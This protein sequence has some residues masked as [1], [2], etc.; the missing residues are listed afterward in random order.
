M[1]SATPLRTEKYFF[2]SG[3]GKL[4]LLVLVV[5]LIVLVMAK[6]AR[7][8][9]AV[10]A[11]SSGGGGYGAGGG[12]SQIFPFVRLMGEPHMFS[13]PALGQLGPRSALLGLA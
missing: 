1:R 5:A 10:A 12:Y 3:V 4:D 6:I 8:K 2:W 9:K 13:A 7:S 11:Y